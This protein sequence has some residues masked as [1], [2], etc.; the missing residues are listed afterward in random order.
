MKR[1]YIA[2]VDLIL[3]VFAHQNP[4]PNQHLISKLTILAEASDIPYRI[5][6]NKSDLIP[7]GNANKLA[8]SY[9]DYGYEV[10]STSTLTHQG[11]RTL[12]SLLSGKTAVFAGPSGVG[13]SALL[14]MLAPGLSLKTGILSEKIGRGKH[15]TREVQLLP[16]NHNTYAADT[17]GFSQVD[18][19][20]LAPQ[21]LAQLFPDFRAHL[22]KC[23]F[24]T[25]IHHAEP[26]CAIKEA[27][28]GGAVKPERYQLYLDL[29]TEVKH[30]WENRY[31]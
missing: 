20:F 14:N 2:N 29:L 17:P 25:C 31:R 16:I 18:L 7:K 1:P 3:L 30:N 27:V 23:R 5:I 10:L 9:R 24:S 12:Q 6:F 8:N 21:E 11:K 13:K 15:T 26:E 28:T 19:D 22:D 4:D